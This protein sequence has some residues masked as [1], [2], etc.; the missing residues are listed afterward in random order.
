[1]DAS[2]TLLHHV[3]ALCP[4]WRPDDVSGF[5]YLEG[6]YSNDNYRFRYGGT[7]YVLRVPLRPRPFVDHR[8]ERQVHEALAAA[9]STPDG[10]RL[11][12][13]VV[14]L[15]V[16][17][18]RMISRWVEGPLLADLE[19]SDDLAL[20][21]AGHLAHLHRRLPAIER[22]YDPVAH[23]AGYL[24]RC[25]APLWIERLASR[26]SW[27][28]ENP[29]TCHNDLN[30]WNLIQS[31]DGGWTTLDWE[32]AGRNDPLFDL[33]TLHQGAGLSPALLAPMAERL[34]GAAV[35][36]RRLVACTVALWFR[37]S[38]WA[39]A[40]LSAGNDRPEI[41]AQWQLGQRRLQAL[42]AAGPDTLPG[43]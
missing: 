15:D 32:W 24:E 28:P 18:G 41:R 5:V 11:G 38:L 29:G 36:V 31:A 35:P 37:E 13:V 10:A 1:M 3:L 4:D 6:G 9:A 22:H 20:P 12:P 8:V 30:P 14:A 42:E 2:A 33:V 27:A 34:T 25:S 19:D 23:G 21:L 16:D 43:V 39:L 17:T 7:R 26:L 40:E